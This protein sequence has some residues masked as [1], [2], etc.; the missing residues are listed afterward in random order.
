MPWAS[1]KTSIVTVPITRHVT[2]KRNESAC[3]KGASLRRHH[4]NPFNEVEGPGP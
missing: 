1:P 4:G 3:A 2:D